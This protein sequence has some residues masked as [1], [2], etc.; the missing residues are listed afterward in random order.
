MLLTTGLVQAVPKGFVAAIPSAKIDDSSDEN[1]LPLGEIIY[2][3]SN[4]VGLHVGVD[5]TLG[6]Q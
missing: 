2:N 3:I 4:G 1:S 6:S 5:F